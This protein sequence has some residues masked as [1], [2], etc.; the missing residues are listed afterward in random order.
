L[1]ANRGIAVCLEIEHLQRVRSRLRA[2][3]LLCP[4]KAAQAHKVNGKGT[5]RPMALHFQRSEF[6]ARLAAAR[7]ALERERLDAILLFA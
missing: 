5:T 2:R 1:P 4:L 7:A 3:P 6:D